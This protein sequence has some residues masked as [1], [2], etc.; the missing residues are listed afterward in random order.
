MNCSQTLKLQTST[1]FFSQ[2]SLFLEVNNLKNHCFYEHILI[3]TK[4]TQTE[5][6]K[7]DKGKVPY[8]KFRILKIYL[9]KELGQTLLNSKYS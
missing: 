8:F 5:Q 1:L 3:E 2:E 4:S 9:A 7:N 6:I